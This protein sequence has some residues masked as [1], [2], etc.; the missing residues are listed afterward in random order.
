[1]LCEDGNNKP[2]GFF[3]GEVCAFCEAVLKLWRRREKAEGKRTPE[4][5]LLK[6]VFSECG[7]V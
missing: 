7:L 6:A 1:M 4:H 3:G 2:E 5:L